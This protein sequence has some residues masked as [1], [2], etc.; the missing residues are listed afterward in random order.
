VLR[1]DKDATLEDAAQRAVE[2]TRRDIRELR[3]PSGWLPDEFTV[4][5]AHRPAQLYRLK[6]TMRK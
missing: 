2:S 3:F 5:D 1:I 6:R 4:G